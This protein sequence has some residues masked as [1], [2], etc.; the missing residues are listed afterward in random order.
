MITIYLTKTQ[1]E[2][3]WMVGSFGAW[4]WRWRS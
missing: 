4:F 3:R 1:K 2:T